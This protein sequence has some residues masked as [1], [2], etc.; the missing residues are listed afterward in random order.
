MKGAHWDGECPVRGV[1][2]EMTCYMD[3]TFY[4]SVFSS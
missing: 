4:A 1:C 2:V 3:F